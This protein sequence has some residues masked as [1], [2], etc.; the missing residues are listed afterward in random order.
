[1]YGI[2]IFKGLKSYIIEGDFNTW[3]EEHRNI[4]I[5]EFKYRVNDAEGY[6]VAILYE[7]K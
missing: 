4:V 6:S 2:K 1:M 5:K 7:E 3:I